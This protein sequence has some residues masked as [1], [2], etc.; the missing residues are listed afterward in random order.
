MV[1]SRFVFSALFGIQY[2]FSS[3]SPNPRLEDLEALGPA[4]FTSW[5]D[6][7]LHLRNLANAKERESKTSDLKP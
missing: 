2:L 3:G 4:V 6:P 5:C 1:F 7:Q